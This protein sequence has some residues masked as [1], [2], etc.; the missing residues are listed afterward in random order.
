MTFRAGGCEP[1]PPTTEEGPE[2]AADVG[3]RRWRFTIVGVDPFLAA[4]PWTY[5]MALPLTVMSAIAV[6]GVFLNYL[7]KAVAPK[8]PKQ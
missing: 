5:W 4:K 7:R 1:V 2:G 6:I 8:Y 3:S